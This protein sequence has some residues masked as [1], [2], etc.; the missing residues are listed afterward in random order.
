MAALAH[1]D[2][3]LRRV[4]SDAT[5]DVQTTGMVCAICLEVFQS[6]GVLLKAMPH[7]LCTHV[8]HRA[9]GLMYLASRDAAG[10]LQHCCPLCRHDWRKDGLLEIEVLRSKSGN[11]RVLRQLQLVDLPNVRPPFFAAG[12]AGRAPSVAAPP[13]RSIPS[14]VA[15]GNADIQCYPD[16]FDR[17][18]GAQADNSA[19]EPQEEIPLP[20][21]GGEMRIRHDYVRPRRGVHSCR[22]KTSNGADEVLHRC[23]LTGKLVSIEHGSDHIKSVFSSM[24]SRSCTRQNNNVKPFAGG[25][26]QTNLVKF[27]EQRPDLL[28]S[29]DQELGTTVVNGYLRA[30]ICSPEA[31][32]LA[33]PQLAGRGATTSGNS[34]GDKRQALTTMSA[35][36]FP[37]SV[38]RPRLSH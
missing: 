19:V 28:G 13:T 34:V 2:H 14:F 4:D 21:A 37:V 36:C 25:D 31:V 9:C 29:L 15:R 18:G 27:A 16:N 8:F 35:H 3:I 20:H 38:K 1:E 7:S 11:T 32:V 10:D 12:F 24:A 22:G 5:R 17:A 30:P 33:W 6:P 26:V 23:P